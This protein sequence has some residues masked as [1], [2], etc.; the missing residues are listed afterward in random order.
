MGVRLV[1]KQGMAELDAVETATED[2]F[3]YFRD[4]I[5]AA[6]DGSE[7][8]RLF[9]SFMHKHFAGWEPAEVAG[10]VKDFEAIHAAMRKLPPDPPDG[11]WASKLIR[12]GRKPATLAEVYVDKSGAPLLERLIALARLARDKGLGVEWE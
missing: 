4:S 8:G 12:S 6:L 2:D 1:V 9:P 3:M 7:F 11:N 10:L 5:H